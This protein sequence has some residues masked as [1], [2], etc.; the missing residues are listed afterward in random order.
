MKFG[1]IEL[2]AAL[3]ARLAHTV[4]LA[5]RVL[6]KGAVLDRDA[7]D[8][9]RISGRTQ[10][11]AAMI[12]PDEIDENEAASR[13]A[14]AIA[15]PGLDVSAATTGRA[16]LVATDNG[17]L[18]IDRAA[19]DRVNFIDEAITVATLP[20]DVPVAAGEV[21]ATIKIIPFALQ[22]TLLDQLPTGAIEL[23]K[24]HPLRAL[25]VQTESN[26]TKQSVLDKTREVTEL[27]L[28]ALGSSLVGE[29]RCTHEIKSIAEAIVTADVDLILLV[30]ASAIVDR[31]DVIP[32]AIESVGGVI[33]RYGMPVDPGN[34]LLLAR[35]GT[36][37]IVGMPGCAR[38]P[39]LNG[40][41][42]VLRRLA[43]GL[44]LDRM[45]IARMGVGGLLP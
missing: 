24:L 21:V 41:D 2:D 19:I 38:S 43:A 12:E 29:T 15:G 17:L 36:I 27:R 33:E 4:R 32:A 31:R 7:I 13:V 16:D 11:A 5:D 10:V 14:T 40:I 6:K 23:R 25:L 1:D 9:L 20:P 30:G 44:P 22:S 28:K 37:P 42:L 35:Y 26:A 3:G 34:L 18:V 39:A 45:V 8:S